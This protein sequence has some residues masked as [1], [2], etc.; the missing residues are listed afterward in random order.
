MRS[1]DEAAQEYLALAQAHFLRLEQD[2]SEATSAL[3]AALDDLARV[4]GGGRDPQGIVEFGEKL[5]DHNRTVAERTAHLRRR[6]ER[7][8]GLEPLTAGQRRLADAESQGPGGR[9]PRRRKERLPAAGPSEG[10]RLL[11]RHM[12]A[13]GYTDRRIL[14]VL[15]TMGVE[16]PDEALKAALR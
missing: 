4:A 1:A 6:V 13:S 9:A 15:K 5:I 7:R 2:A 3:E 16:D 14:A 8:G 10:V 12:A 11:T